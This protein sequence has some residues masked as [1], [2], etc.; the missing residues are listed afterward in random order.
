[1]VFNLGNKMYLFF[2]ISSNRENKLSKNY[3]LYFLRFQTSIN[4]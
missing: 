2:E 4:Y 1:M 3:E